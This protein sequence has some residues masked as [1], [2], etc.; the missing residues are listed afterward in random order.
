[1]VIR[2]R[3]VRRMDR[4]NINAAALEL[5]KHIPFPKDAFAL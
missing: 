2:G 5:L 1:M 4:E 3:D